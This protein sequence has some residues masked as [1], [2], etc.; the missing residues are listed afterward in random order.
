MIRRQLLPAGLALGVSLLALAQEPAKG[1]PRV[2]ALLASMSLEDKVSQMMMSYPP[3]SK[4]D[5]VTVGSVIFVGNLLKSE[6]KV[7]ARVADLSSRARIPL[8]VAA[9]VEGG[10]LNKLGFLPGLEAVPSNRELG[11]A[12]PDAARLWGE[13]V[14]LGMKRLGLNCA[15]APVLDVA[16]AGMMYDSGRSFSAEPQQVAA[17]GRAYLEGLSAAGVV[18]VG[19][20]WPGYGELATNTDHHLVVTQRS[21]EDVAREAGAFVTVGD[22]MVGVMLANVG[23]SSYGGVPAILSR[24]LVDQAHARGWLTITDDLAIGALAE[25]TD[26][27]AE[28][29]V[30]QAFLAG[31]DILLTTAP[32]DWDKALDYRGVV[33]ELVRKD[34]ALTARVDDSVRRILT[35]KDHMGILR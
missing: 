12:G 1:S 11:E 13:R 26:G 28:E 22:R 24:D 34:P 4:T 32:I 17:L 8:L 35:L 2:E 23:Y 7:T 19:K 25:A 31:N 5:P 16:G 18:G 14:G 29:L 20:H 10:A 15:L 27:D 30:R 9:D 6:D 3:I 33:L 21:R